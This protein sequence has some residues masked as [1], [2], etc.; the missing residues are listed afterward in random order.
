M[1]DTIIVRVLR[2]LM[3]RSQ[4]REAGQTIRATALEAAELVASR[5][6]ELAHAADAAAV[7]AAQREA[8]RRAIKAEGRPWHAPEAA[9]PWQRITR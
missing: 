3:F 2:P 9:A 8:I 6:A 5:R 4:R 7:A 1:A